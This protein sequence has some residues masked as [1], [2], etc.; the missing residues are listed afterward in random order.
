MKTIWVVV[1]DEAIARILVWPETGNEL[2]SVEELTD[3]A[4]HASG[5]DLR[6]DA[7]GRRSGSA[8]H[9]ASPGSPHRLRSSGNVTSSAGEGEQHQEADSF[10]HRVAQH[11]AEALQQKRYD[12]LRIVAAPR[13][14]GLLR[15][16]LD[17]HVSATVSDELSKDLIHAD[18]AELTR[19]LFPEPA[20]G[21]PAA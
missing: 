14:L 16:E 11:L 18:N 5:S 17:A 19:R 21:A 20:G 2:V 4:A 13:F 7:Y 12:E 3:P 6:R 1:A 15:K 8:T 10:A 9:G